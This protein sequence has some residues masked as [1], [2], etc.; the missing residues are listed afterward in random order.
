M[1]A[2]SSSFTLLQLPRRI[3]LVVI[4]EN[5]RSTR[6]SQELCVGVKCTTNRPGRAAKNSRTP[7]VS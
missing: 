6:F 3:L 1:I 7:L 4:S 5:Q 2:R